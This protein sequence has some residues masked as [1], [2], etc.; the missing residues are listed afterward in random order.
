MAENLS[1]N[2]FAVYLSLFSECKS[3]F[4]SLMAEHTEK[5][6]GKKSEK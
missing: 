2:F 3:G 6:S 4:L 5:E 1:D